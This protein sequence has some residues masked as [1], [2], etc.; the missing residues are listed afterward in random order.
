M[1]IKGKQT[2]QGDNQTDKQ[3]KE[4]TIQTNKT[5]RRPDK[6]TRQRDNQTNKQDKRHP[7]RH[8]DKQYNKINILE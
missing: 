8:T 2:R 7:E 4:T 5:I 6:Q 1:R 3:D